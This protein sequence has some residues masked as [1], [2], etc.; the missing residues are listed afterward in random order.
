MIAHSNIQQ[1]LEDA[2]RHKVFKRSVTSIL[3]RI[4]HPCFAV[5]GGK[6]VALRKVVIDE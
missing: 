6:A 1:N 3:Q 5:C 4:L 2:Q